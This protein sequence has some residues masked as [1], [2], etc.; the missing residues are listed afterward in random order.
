MNVGDFRRAALWLGHRRRRWD[1]G[2]LS[3]RFV[4]G[5]VLVR[6]IGCPNNTATP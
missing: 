2:L 3:L 4:H 5:T 1:F 6:R